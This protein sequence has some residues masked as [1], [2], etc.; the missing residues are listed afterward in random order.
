MTKKS[1]SIITIVIFL[2][3][4]VDLI[5]SMAK[6]Q[7]VFWVSGIAFLSIV[8]YLPR[9]KILFTFTFSILCGLL[10]GSNL[11]AV[12]LCYFFLQ[13]VIGMVPN[14]ILSNLLESLG[15]FSLY[16]VLSTMT[17]PIGFILVNT[18]LAFLL[19]LL[20][21]NRVSTNYSSYSL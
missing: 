2:S 15:F 1:V 5:L 4:V 13:L 8:S 16:A 18:F 20:L 3:F 11:G 14:R 19:V 10:L 7:T 17:L 21:S 12:A 6:I 9:S